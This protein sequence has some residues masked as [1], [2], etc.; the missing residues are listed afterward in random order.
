MTV[1]KQ[2]SHVTPEQYLALERQATHKSEY[3]NGHVVAMAGASR[4]HNLIAGNIYRE[5]SSQLK[6]KPCEAYI[7]DMRVKVA[8]TH[9]YTYPDIVAV[10]GDI[11][12][13]D[14]H[15]DTLLNPMVIIEVLSASTEAYDR[16][17]KF[18]H[19]RRLTALQDYL[20]VSQK[21]AC[22][23]HYFRQGRQ[24]ILSEYNRLDD[25][26]AL[27]SIACKL[28]VRDIYDKIEFSYS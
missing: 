26:V 28:V 23:E 4:A 10:C 14:K 17:D 16:G 11:E 21:K 27:A 12:F 19:Y 13:D 7:S 25:E 24:W 3:I 22:V 20:L 9:L 15:G 18:A 2:A 8:A 5:V 6:G 1:V